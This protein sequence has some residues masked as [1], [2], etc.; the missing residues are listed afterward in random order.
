MISMLII[1]KI[2]FG[3]LSRFSIA[4]LNLQRKSFAELSR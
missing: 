3:G 4:K 1:M 2:V